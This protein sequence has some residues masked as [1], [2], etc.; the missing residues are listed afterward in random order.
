MV[1]YYHAAAGFPVKATWI[2]VISNNQYSSWPGLSNSRCSREAFSAVLSPR[3][4]YLPARSRCQQ[5][6]K[7]TIA[8][9][10][11]ESQR[12]DNDEV[13]HRH[14]H[15][16]GVATRK[17][18]GLSKSVKDGTEK[19]TV[20]SMVA[21][22]GTTSGVGRSTDPFKRTG[23]QS[24]KVFVLPDG[25]HTE[26]AELARVEHKLR[27]PARYMHMTPGTTSA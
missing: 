18:Q 12:H 4:Q 13:L 14:T 22:S 8:G 16:R 17:R 9:A 1:W 7:R 23:K 20:S 24:N 21:D 27:E 19:G 10:P 5:S 6:F 11:D 26:S 25:A 3:S 2:K 15:R